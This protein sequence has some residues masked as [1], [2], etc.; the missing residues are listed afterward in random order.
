MALDATS[1]ALLNKFAETQVALNDRFFPRGQSEILLGDLIDD[2]TNDKK[3]VK[4]SYNFAQQ[5]GA[6]G[7]YLLLK[8]DGSSFQLPENAILTGLWTRMLSTFAS[9]GLAT[10]GLKTGAQVIKAQTAFDNVDWTGVDDQTA[11]AQTNT[12][13]VPTLI[14]ATGSL[15]LEVADADLT[16]G[17]VDLWVEYLTP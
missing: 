4:C 2:A 14:A 1:K 15:L 10:V 8:A 5:G 13:T 11:A 12:V 17:A 9:G 7:D 16:G 6:V 3:T